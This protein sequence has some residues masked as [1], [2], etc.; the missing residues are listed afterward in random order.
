MGQPIQPRPKRV[1]VV[2]ADNPMVEVHGEFFWREDHDVLVAAARDEGYRE[3]YGAGWSDATRRS[4][5]PQTVIL[6]RR[7]SLSGRI[8]RVL[9]GVVLLGMLLIVLGTIVGQLIAQR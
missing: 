9:L 2:D 4:A 6:R 8:R 5:S 1:V 7:L 3:G